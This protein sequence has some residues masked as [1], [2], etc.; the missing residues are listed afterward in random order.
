MRQVKKIWKSI[1]NGGIVTTFRKALLVRDFKNRVAQYRKWASAYADLDGIER[2]RILDLIEQFSSRPLISIVMP[3]Y[4][5]DERYFRQAI[6][7][8]RSQLYE[9][10]ELCLADDRSTAVHIRPTID[11][12][13]KTD[14]RIHAIYRE[15]NGHISAASNSALGM[16][17]GKF[18]VLMDHDDVITEDALFQVAKLLNE[19]PDTELIYTDED[20]IDANGKQLSPMFKPQWSPEFFHSVNLLTH[21]SVYRTSRLREI[22]GFREGYEGSQDYD[23]ALRY[24][25][26]IDDGEI[27]HMPHV[28]YHWRAIA[29]SVA[30]S[31]GEKSYAHENARKALN[32]HFDRCGIRAM[33]VKGVD[34]MHRLV[35]DV[36]N[37]IRVSLVFGTSTPSRDLLESIE[38]KKSAL[39]CEIIVCND[40]Q[41]NGEK[42]STKPLFE[43]TGRARY[44]ILN[45]AASAAKGDVIIF[46]D[47][48]TV[49][50]SDGWLEELVGRASL[51]GVGAVGAKIIDKQ[52]RII[53]AGYL[54]GIKDGVGRAHH[55]YPANGVGEF[56]RLSI[57]QNFSAVSVRC[58][59]IRR[60][61]FESVNGFDD[62]SFPENYADID[63]CLRLKEK[64]F[65]TAWTPWVEVVQTTD[66]ILPANP[67]LERLKVKF[68]A[69]FKSDPYYN[70]NLTRSSEDLS[71][72][73][74]PRISRFN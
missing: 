72:A 61:V 36:P 23:L 17:S 66:D 67:E 74:P 52:D 13:L 14:S 58:M 44:Q 41:Q 65:R 5:V 43:T 56:V 30:R 9:N 63:L 38:S 64:G 46:V 33:A 73:F 24:I 32:E 45:Q 18:V 53:H 49:E 1:L 71:L 34:E 37:G 39:V 12:Y 55:Q 68:K 57:D 59:A 16:A 7:S 25:E 54:L 8:I 28:L 47:S 15:K 20:K 40:G 19:Y 62:S 6:D 29:G 50:A 2:R 35:F 31:T 4:N 21:L 22:G 42:N 10:W 11:E 70:P 3:V 69:A 48:S 26:T 60:E 27:K 51:P